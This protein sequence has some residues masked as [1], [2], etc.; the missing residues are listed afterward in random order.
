MTH[1]PWMAACLLW[2][3][4]VCLTSG[5]TDPKQTTLLV[6]SSICADT[7]ATVTLLVALLRPHISQ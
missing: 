1:R 3:R 5:D 7:E 2:A 6:F 4:E